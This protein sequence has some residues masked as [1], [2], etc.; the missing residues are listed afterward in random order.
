MVK[1]AGNGAACFV[2]WIDDFWTLPEG[3]APRWQRWRVMRLLTML[4]FY[5]TRDAVV[6]SADR[7]VLEVGGKRVELSVTGQ[8][9]GVTD[10]Q[11]K[12][13]VNLRGIVAAARAVGARV[14]LL[15]Y[16]ADEEAY[17]S[18]NQQIRRLAREENVPLIDVGLAM[19][20]R[21]PATRPVAGGKPEHLPLAER[22]GLF[23]ADGHP[24]V[25]G[26]DAIAQA[27]IDGDPT[28][29]FGH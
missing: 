15:T 24:T 27:L 6:P 18:V 21:C 14:V 19:R 16:A 7:H 29:D 11:A 26:Y 13:L 17:A 22:C 8:G 2:K 1:L 23:L 5:C 28:L 12:M 3:E 20:R 4:W 9:Y 25:A 10:W